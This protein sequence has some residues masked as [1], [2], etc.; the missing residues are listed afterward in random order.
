LHHIDTDLKNSVVWQISE[1]EDN[2][3]GQ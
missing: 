3:V 1:W 2:R